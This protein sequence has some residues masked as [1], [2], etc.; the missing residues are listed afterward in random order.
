MTPTNLIVGK[1]VTY[2]TGTRGSYR[3]GTVLA[4]SADLTSLMIQ[5]TK[6]RYDREST[7]SDLRQYDGTD[8]TYPIDTMSSTDCQIVPLPTAPGGG[9]H[10]RIE[11]REPT[12]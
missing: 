6:Y 1:L 5:P 9:G 10:Y 8:I 2:Y 7:W 3:S 12:P 11:H 4:V